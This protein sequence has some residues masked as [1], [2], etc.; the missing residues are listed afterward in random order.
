M[1]GPVQALYLLAIMAGLGAALYWFYNLLVQKPE[2]EEEQRKAR[3]EA[4]KA[5]R[6]KKKQ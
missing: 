2:L 4:K 1:S 3:L 5:K 6:D